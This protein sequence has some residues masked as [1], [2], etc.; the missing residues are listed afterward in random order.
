LLRNKLFSTNGRQL[1]SIFFRK[2][3]VADFSARAISYT[4]PDAIICPPP[5]A[6]EEE[7]IESG[8]ECG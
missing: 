7:I 3:P 1:E 8:Y 4:V 5:G 6:A 2:L